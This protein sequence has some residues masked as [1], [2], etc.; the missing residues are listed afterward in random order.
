MRIFVSLLA[1]TFVW[2]LAPHSARAAA[3]LCDARGA[4]TFAPNPTLEEPNSSVD[5]G[6]DDCDGS[7]AGEQ[8]YDHG[9]TPTAIDAASEG[10]RALVAESPRILAATP[11]DELED[12]ATTFVAP[13][14]VRARV[15]RPPR[16]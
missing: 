13:S 4:I 2:L 14:G 15:D 16:V 6:Q 5:V 3:P 11:S 7:G 10:V 12:A 9:R 8:S 1:A